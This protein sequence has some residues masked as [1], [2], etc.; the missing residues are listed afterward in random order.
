[1]LSLTWLNIGF[2]DYCLFIILNVWR[3]NILTFNKYLS[4]I[5]VVSFKK[6]NII[7]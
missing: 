2:I 4:E 5:F 6:K 7:S 3:L 1:M